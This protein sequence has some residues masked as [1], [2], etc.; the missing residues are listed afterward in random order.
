MLETRDEERPRALLQNDTEPRKMRVKCQ[1]PNANTETILGLKNTWNWR[2][3][4]NPV[5]TQQTPST[6]FLCIQCATG[7]KGFA[8]QLAIVIFFI[9]HCK[10]EEQTSTLLFFYWK[11]L[12]TRDISKLSIY[13]NKDKNMVFSI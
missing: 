8:I 10:S 3:L 9:Q 1:D 12:I 4:Q 6:H 5:N 7:Y 11:L 2:L 13:C